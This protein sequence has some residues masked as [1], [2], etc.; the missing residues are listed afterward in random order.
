MHIQEVT[1]QIDLDRVVPFFQPV[2]DLT[3]NA[4][5]CYECL[6]RLMRPGDSPYLPCDF[7]HLIERQNA[8]SVLTETIFL[9]SAEYF[10]HINMAWNINISQHDM[11]NPDLLP[12]LQDYMLEFPNPGRFSLEMTAE[13]AL[14][15]QPEFDAFV[16]SCQRLGIGLVID[17]LQGQDPDSLALLNYPLRAVKVAGS[18]IGQMG[19][20][21]QIGE[22]VSLI[23]QQASQRKVAVIAEHVEDQQTLSAIQ[24]AGLTL[25]QGFLFSKPTAVIR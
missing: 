2:M 11:T 3:N 6:A 15:H 13:T 21:P 14:A 25:G 10:R 4:V 7:L 19:D 20:N 12:M 8:A 5:W 24:A 18:L 23:H 1:D 22:Q 17:H 16:E 9:R